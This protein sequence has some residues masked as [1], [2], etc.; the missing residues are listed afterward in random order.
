MKEENIEYNISDIIEKFYKW[1]KSEWLLD[2]P[3]EEEFLQFAGRIRV[4]L[5]WLYANKYRIIKNYKKRRKDS[6]T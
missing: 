2:K 6:D 3:N 4:F 5:N 1:L